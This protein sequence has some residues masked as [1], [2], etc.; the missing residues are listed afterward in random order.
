M[1]RRPEGKEPSIVMGE[2][3]EP[4]PAG[5]TVERFIEAVV[6]GKPERTGIGWI[7]NFSADSRKQVIRIQRIHDQIGVVIDRGDEGC[8][9]DTA[10]AKSGILPGLAAVGGLPD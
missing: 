1:R 7:D 6:A 10:G 3:L 2:V 5:A 8:E 4:E 9:P